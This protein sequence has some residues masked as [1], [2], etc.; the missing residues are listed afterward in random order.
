[1]EQTDTTDT[2]AD[3]LMQYKNSNSIFEGV[4]L[5]DEASHPELEKLL[6][7][8]KKPKSRSYMRVDSPT[9]KSVIQII[10][11]YF[12]KTRTAQKKGVFALRCCFV[13]WFGDI[14]D[15]CTH[16]FDEKFRFMTD[17]RN[18]QLNNN[19]DDATSVITMDE[20]FDSETN[21]EQTA[22]EALIRKLIIYYAS[23]VQLY[24]ERQNLV[25]LP[26]IVYSSH[27]RPELKEHLRCFYGTENGEMTV[28]EQRDTQLRTSVL[29][30][31]KEKISQESI[32]RLIRANF[33]LYEGTKKL[34]ELL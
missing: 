8:Y 18:Y 24:D 26:S 12:D 28:Q 7:L 5:N 29:Y 33:G 9:F 31:V 3:E 32:D 27:G 11:S 22:K 6:F 23:K 30:T 4:R 1:M 17:K 25:G 14:P 16:I 20:S 21:F 2:F 10:L 13:F 15:P 34:Y 19:K